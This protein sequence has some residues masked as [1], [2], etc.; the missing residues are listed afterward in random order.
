MNEAI[1]NMLDRRSCRSFD[2]RLIS[3]DELNAIL[4]AGLYAPTGRGHQAP[5][6]VA[7]QNQ[8]LIKKLSK[9]NAEIMGTSMD[10]FYGATTLIIVLAERSWPTHVY[11]GSLVIG[12]ILNAAAS[13]G[14]GACWIHRAKEEFDSPE[15]KALL[16][17][18]GIKGDYEG[19]GHVILGYPAG[20]APEAAPRKAGYIT[21]VK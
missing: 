18:W 4:Q 1:Q 10:P 14:I 17:E 19:I 3:E 6:I 8:K 9:M 2:G 16:K 11:D 5:I 13:L 20:P 7:T 21:I 12:N 15:G